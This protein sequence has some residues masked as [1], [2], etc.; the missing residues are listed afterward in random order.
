MTLNFQTKDVP[1]PISLLF[2]IESG[3]RILSRTR[4]QI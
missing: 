1:T 3:S 2:I 4:T